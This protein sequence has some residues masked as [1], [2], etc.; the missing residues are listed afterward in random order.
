MTR[1]SAPFEDRKRM[2]Y[3]GEA[4]VK[5]LMQHKRPLVSNYEIF[6]YL[7]Q[8]YAQG[9]VKYLRSDHPNKESY[10]RTRTLL[11]AEG[12]LRKDLDYR[13][14]WRVLSLS[15]VAADEAV[16][17]ADP[18]CY[19]S[20]LSAM[21]RYGLTDRRPDALFITQPDSATTQALLKK[22]RQD[23]FAHALTEP[24]QFV[25]RLTA[26]KHPDQVRQ[27]PLSCLSSKHLGHY[28]E[29]RGGFARIA[30][31]GQTFLDMVEFPERCGGMRHVIDVWEE[32]AVT[33]LEEIIARIDTAPKDIHKI[34]AGYILSEHLG[35]RDARVLLWQAY[36]QRGGS[37]LLDPERPYSD[38]FSEDWM[39]S[40]NV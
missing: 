29:V 31:I 4:L 10:Q 24:D 18:Y 23:Q 5:L 13:S 11:K 1:K 8:L 40:I 2:T 16:C 7:W 15:D 26:I 34:R 27:R 37:R 32:H 9:D 28:R 21:Q 6:S 3:L 17:L 12:I 38:H 19:I 35:I 36:A 30:S 22:R 20:H 25:E 33:Y 14:L 39:L